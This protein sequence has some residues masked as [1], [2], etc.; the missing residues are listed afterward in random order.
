[1]LMAQLIVL[2]PPLLTETAGGWS[3]MR[4]DD[5]GWHVFCAAGRSKRHSKDDGKLTPRNECFRFERERPPRRLSVNQPGF[6]DGNVSKES[7]ILDII[8]VSLTLIKD[9][10]PPI[11][12]ESTDDRGIHEKSGTTIRAESRLFTSKG[13]KHHQGQDDCV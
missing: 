13:P 6:D 10:S 9:L 2:F 11:E 4:N 3:G 5:Q 1:M 7:S 12:A 8:A